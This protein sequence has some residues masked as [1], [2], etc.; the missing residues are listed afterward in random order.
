MASERAGEAR[1]AAERVVELIQAAGYLLDGHT[2]IDAVRVPTSNAPVFGGMGGEVR[3][4]G[5]RQRFKRGEERV[6][7]G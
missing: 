2:E 6:T 4:F 1:K 3:T 5:G 7:K